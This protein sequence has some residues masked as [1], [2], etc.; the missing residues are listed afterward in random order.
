MPAPPGRASSCSRGPRL[1]RSFFDAAARAAAQPRLPTGRAFRAARVTAAAARRPSRRRRARHDLGQPAVRR[2]ASPPRAAAARVA[3]LRRRGE[4]PLRRGRSSRGSPS[5]T[6]PRPW[7]PTWRSWRWPASCYG[8]RAA[9]T[10]YR[11]GA[12]RG[13]SNADLRAGCTCDGAGD[14]TLRGRTVGLLG[15]GRI[16]RE[17]A[18]AA[19]ALR[20]AA[21]RATIPSSR[22]RVAR[23]ARGRAR[24]RP[25][26]GCWRA[27][28]TWSW[29]RP[30]P[31]ET[32]GLLDA[33]AL[34]PA[35]RRRHRRQRR[36]RRPRRP[37]RAHARGPPRAAALRAG[38]DRPRG[39]A[40]AAASAAPDARGRAHAPRGR[41][42]ARG[43]PGDGRRSCSTTSSASSAGGASRNRVTA[44]HAEAG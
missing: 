41:R 14:E 2:G 6:R 34:A 24:R 17:I 43:P 40:A 21:P 29:P 42:P 26:A 4:G 7:R 12:A 5:R 9:S 8:G 25:G 13:R 23:G 30:S 38:R 20:R 22:A 11:D 16:G 32:R 27:R 39:A 1:F 18:R 28:A 36:P 19:R 15:F 10:S 44:G 35:P 37:G 3:P 31:S 33:S